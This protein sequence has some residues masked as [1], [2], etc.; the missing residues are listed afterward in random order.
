MRE[1]EPAS[2][3]KGDQID[4]IAQL[5]EG[6]DDVA[7]R[8]R[9]SAILVERLRSHHQDAVARGCARSDADLAR[10][11]PS[12]G[13]D[14]G[15]LGPIHHLHQPTRLCLPDAA[16]VVAVALAVLDCPAAAGKR[17]HPDLARRR[18]SA[19]RVTASKAG[20]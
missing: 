8:D 12:S 15:P 19:L 2:E 1:L 11:V 13:S 9:R 17:S 14:P 5:D 20:C 18:R 16:A 4:L 6:F 10:E 7:Q 3:R